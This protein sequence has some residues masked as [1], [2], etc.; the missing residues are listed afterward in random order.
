[1]TAISFPLSTR[2]RPTRPEGLILRGAA[3][4]ARLVALRMS[5][6]AAH[7]G[8]RDA[9]DVATEHR[10]DAVAAYALGLHLR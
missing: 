7:L 6:R 3:A 4:V 9:Q 2:V 10:R 8:V 1:M 5:R